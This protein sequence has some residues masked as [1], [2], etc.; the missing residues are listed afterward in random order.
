MFPV[1][2]PWRLIR[3]YTYVG[4]TVLDPFLGSGSTAKAAALGERNSVGYEINNE[5]KEMIQRKITGEN[6]SLFPNEKQAEII[7]CNR[8]NNTVKTVT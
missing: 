5:L 3:M 8:T 6:I 2:L 1:E 7:F 4:E